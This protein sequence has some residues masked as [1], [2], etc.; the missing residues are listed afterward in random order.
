MT[1][2]VHYCTQQCL[3]CWRAQSGDLNT[4]WN[5]MLLPNL[6]PI[7]NIV[8]G[9]LEAQIALLSGYGGNPK[10]N[11][12]KFREALMPKH[13]AISLA[14]EPTLYTSLGELI[15]SFHKKGFTTF[16]VSNG[17][18]PERLS[19]IC[20]EPTQLYISLCAPN[21]EVFQ[22]LCRPHKPESWD[23]LN[24]TLN[25]IPS[26]HCPTVIRMTLVKGQ[27]MRLF[28]EYA[29]LL[30]RTN[31]TYIEVKAYMHIGFS[32]LRLSYE[33]MPG[34]KGV[35]EF[36]KCLSELTGYE[37]ID[38]SVESRVVLLSKRKKALR[39]DAA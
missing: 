33:N 12:R 19:K 10:T 34:H 1:P 15:H 32:G 18:L 2:S 7:D 20:E 26:F 30:E 17:T 9:S 35:F 5:E 3:F 31:P 29:R 25:Y 13:V 8:K 37:I 16:L 23:K 6:D 28:D 22:K 4:K 38:Q 39:F 36:G 27:N 14:G 21:K 24:E 11:W